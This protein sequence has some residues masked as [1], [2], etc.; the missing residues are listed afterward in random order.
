MQVAILSPELAS[1][2]TSS[3]AAAEVTQIA[4][5]PTSNQLAA[6]YS[7]GSVRLWD[8]NGRSCLVTLSGHS[9]AVTAL[10]YSSN[11]ALLASGSADTSVIVWDVV[12]ESG[13]CRFKGHK[14]AITDLV[15][16]R[17]ATHRRMGCMLLEFCQADA[18]VAVQ[19]PV[20]CMV[21]SGVAATR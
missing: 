11:G 16:S 13:L 2:S 20:L 7:D 9:G 6:G 15:S 18:S 3:K 12:G 4:L 8:I 21:W 10:R 14:D 5:S 17:A 19:S 1:S